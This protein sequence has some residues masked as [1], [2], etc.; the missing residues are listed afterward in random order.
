MRGSSSW[1]GDIS[2]HVEEALMARKLQGSFRKYGQPLENQGSLQ[3]TARE[4]LSC[5]C[6]EMNSAYNLN[7]LG[8]VFFLSQAFI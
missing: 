1:L 7:E 2:S 5:S 3:L 8:D 4:K 6:K